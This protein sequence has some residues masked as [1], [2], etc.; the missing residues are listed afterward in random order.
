MP[1]F[2]LKDVIIPHLLNQIFFTRQRHHKLGRI[3]AMIGICV[4]WRNLKIRF[5]LTHKVHKHSKCH[6]AVRIFKQAQ[7]Y[8]YNTLPSRLS[9]TWISKSRRYIWQHICKLPL[10]CARRHVFEFLA[11]HLKLQNVAKITLSTSSDW[12]HLHAFTRKTLY[13]LTSCQSPS[14]SQAICI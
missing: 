8:L 5:H 13:N 10:Y 9:K 12:W 11:M 3:Y 4:K 2:R 6:I 7:Y 1:S 14:K